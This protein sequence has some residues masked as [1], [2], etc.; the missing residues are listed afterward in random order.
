M[1][2]YVEPQRRYTAAK[3][4]RTSVEAPVRP[5][6]SEDRADSGALF[7]GVVSIGGDVVDILYINS[8][9]SWK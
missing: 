1:A 6:L 2:K 5:W 9:K 7:D 3:A 8:P 4:A